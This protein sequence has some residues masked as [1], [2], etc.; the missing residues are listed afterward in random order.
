MKAT[1]IISNFR[2]VSL[3]SLFPLCSLLSALL[4]PKI[5]WPFHPLF[6]L[7]LESAFHNHPTQLFCLSYIYNSIW[8][9][10]VILHLVSWLKLWSEEDFIVLDILKC[11]ILLKEL[12]QKR[13]KGEGFLDYSCCRLISSLLFKKLF[14]RFSWSL[15]HVGFIGFCFQ[16]MSLHLTVCVFMVLSYP[17]YL[18]CYFKFRFLFL[19]FHYSAH[20]SLFYLLSFFTTFN[21]TATCFLLGKASTFPL[22]ISAEQDMRFFHT[23]FTAPIS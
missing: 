20:I 2:T 17:R 21:S 8:R 13:P 19:I 7:H 15:T 5:L 6:L 12:W 3:D 4:I 10:C 22:L 9:W 14:L 23:N 16:V 1:I 11:W 18:L